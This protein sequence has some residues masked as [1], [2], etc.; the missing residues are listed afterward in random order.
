MIITAV[1][2]FPIATNLR[3]LFLN[4]QIAIGIDLSRRLQRDPHPAPENLPQRAQGTR[5]EVIL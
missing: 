2:G 5:T 3:L 4:I 1:A